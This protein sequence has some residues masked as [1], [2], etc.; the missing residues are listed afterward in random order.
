MHFAPTAKE[1]NKLGYDAASGMMVAGGSEK[2]GGGRK[3][4]NT[5]RGQFHFATF[6]LISCWFIM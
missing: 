6:T 1:S 2:K 5:E 3:M 4:P